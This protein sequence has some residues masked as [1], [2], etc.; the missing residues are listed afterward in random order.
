M[1]LRRL[2]THH[3]PQRG[4]IQTPWNR[5]WRAVDWGWGICIA[6]WLIQAIWNHFRT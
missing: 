2:F 4:P 1:R 6:L 3:I 5:L